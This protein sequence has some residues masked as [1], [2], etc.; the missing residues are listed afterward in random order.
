MHLDKEMTRFFN[1][2]YH[3]ILLS[4]SSKLKAIE[5]EL[6]LMQSKILVGH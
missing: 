5:L 3:G 1:L 2:V 4:L 6:N